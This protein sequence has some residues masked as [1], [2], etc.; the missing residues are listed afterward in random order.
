MLI[1]LAHF[2]ICFMHSDKHLIFYV[3]TT[4]AHRLIWKNY[5]AWLIWGPNPK[6][7]EVDVKGLH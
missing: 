1:T 2:L 5:V 7:I 6:P 4:C 3:Q